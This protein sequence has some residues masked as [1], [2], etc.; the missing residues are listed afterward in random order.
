[1]DVRSKRLTGVGVS[2]TTQRTINSAANNV[3]LNR[4]NR[5][6][7]LFVVTG[8]QSFFR[9]PLTI[10]QELHRATLW[11]ANY[12]ESKIADSWTSL[13]EPVL[14][15]ITRGSERPPEKDISLAFRVL[16]AVAEALKT[17]K[18]LVLAEIS[19]ELYNKELLRDTDEVRRLLGELFLLRTSQSGLLSV[20]RVG[21]FKILP[22]LL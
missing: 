4:E 20:S 2:G 8:D 9:E 3:S 18:G 13:F 21:Y 22:Q 15:G 1:V 16:T 6:G 7:F 11:Y 5:D 12:L 10:S 14:T 19:D 17:R